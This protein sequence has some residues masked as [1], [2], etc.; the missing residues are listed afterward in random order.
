M[1]NILHDYSDEKCVE[2]LRQ[3]MPA[4]TEDSAILIDEI[5]I[6][7]T[8]AHWH[9]TSMDFLMMATL[10]SLERNE[11]HWRRLLDSAGLKIVKIYTYNSKL[12][13]S[14]TMARRKD[15]FP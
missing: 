5:V 12:G 3:I 15:A 13:E 6:P 1:R 4:M 10:A 8:G 11:D 7:V 2:I 9:A 14:I